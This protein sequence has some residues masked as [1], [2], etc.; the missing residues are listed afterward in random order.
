ME[1][2]VPRL[3]IA[4]LAMAPMLM[5]WLVFRRVKSNRPRVVMAARITSMLASV[6][7]FLF[8]LFLLTA[9]GCEEDRE[10]VGSPD[11][12]H[13]AR[14][15]IWGSVPTGSNLR[16]IERRSW[17]P[18]WQT[19]SRAGSVGTPLEPI[20][21]RI[22]WLNNTHLLLDYPEPVDG[23]GSDCRSRRVEDI[24]LVCRTHEFHDGNSASSNSQ[25]SIP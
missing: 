7:F 22:V 23:T 1:L 17:T 5:L 21:P 14:L 20:E 2:W 18:S 13:V 6:P 24:E 4:S 10:L 8:S 3:E 12:R 16:V 15:M 19:V 25:K 9:Q 11:G